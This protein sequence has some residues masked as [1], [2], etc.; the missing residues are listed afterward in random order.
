MIWLYYARRFSR[1]F[2]YMARNLSAKK[3]REIKSRKV[4]QHQQGIDGLLPVHELTLESHF[5]D[6][7]LNP[8]LVYTAPI[9]ALV[10]GY[11]H[12]SQTAKVMKAL[13]LYGA[14]NARL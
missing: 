7:A 2:L 14:E 5:D 10:K 9:Q 4:L 12:Y 1:A 11:G 13:E 8:I 6:G 3:R